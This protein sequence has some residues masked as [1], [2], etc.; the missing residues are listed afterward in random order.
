MALPEQ[1]PLHKPLRPG[2][3]GGPRARQPWTPASFPKAAAR[4][5]FRLHRG[6]PGT[7]APHY[8]TQ[9]VPLQ[10]LHT[11][12]PPP[13]VPFRHPRWVPGSAPSPVREEGPWPEPCER[14]ARKSP[15]LLLI[16]T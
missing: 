11:A 15:S 8:T 2:Q 4:P 7:L 9:P 3:Q 14:P 13:P 1:H 6:T 5:A 10:P 16:C 12:P